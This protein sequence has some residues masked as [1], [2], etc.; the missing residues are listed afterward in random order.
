MLSRSSLFNNFQVQLDS[1]QSNFS[2]L[3]HLFFILC[4]VFKEGNPSAWTKSQSLSDVTDISQVSLQGGFL[5]QPVF[6]SSP[7][8]GDGQLSIISSTWW[9]KFSGLLSQAAWPPI[10]KS[11]DG[12]KTFTDY[13][14]SQVLIMLVL[15]DVSFDIFIVSIYFL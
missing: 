2:T 14:V 4:K 6:E 15:Q 1:V 11:L 5:K 7:A 3:H 9:K 12:G 8:D 10:L 13:T